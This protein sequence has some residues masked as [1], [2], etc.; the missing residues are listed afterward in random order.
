MDG[1]TKTGTGSNSTTNAPTKDN[2]GS[3]I[4]SGQRDEAKLIALYM[5]LTGCSENAARCVYS[6]L[7][8]DEKEAAGAG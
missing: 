5:E 3:P 6:H 7:E 1:A 8:L 2:A 4:E